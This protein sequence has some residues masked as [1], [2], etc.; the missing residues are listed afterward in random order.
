MLLE[1]SDERTIEGPGFTEQMQ[2]KIGVAKDRWEGRR[3]HIQGAV[4]TGRARPGAACLRKP[5]CPQCQSRRR[6]ADNSTPVKISP[7][8][9]GV[10]AV[11]RRD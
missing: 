7:A 1:Q 11:L 4:D 10:D 9:V 8:Y 3:H 5:L 2:R 6:H